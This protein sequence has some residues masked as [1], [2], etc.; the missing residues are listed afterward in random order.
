MY[1]FGAISAA[2]AVFSEVQLLDWEKL[3]LLSWP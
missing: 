1:H 3:K 2:F